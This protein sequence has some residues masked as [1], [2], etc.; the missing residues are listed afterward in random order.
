MNLFVQ[1]I[2]TARGR[3]EVSCNPLI[4]FLSVRSGAFLLM[5]PRGDLFAVAAALG[6]VLESPNAIPTLTLQTGDSLH[7]GLDMGGEHCWFST[8]DAHLRIDI[9]AARELRGQL[10]AARAFLGDTAAAGEARPC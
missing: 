4:P 10:D 5:L 6:R 1:A 9:A 8:G 2:D 3:M 7:I